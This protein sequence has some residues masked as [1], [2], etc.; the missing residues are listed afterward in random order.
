MN[1][2]FKLN[3]IARRAGHTTMIA[4]AVKDCRGVMICCDS[5]NASQVAK[6]F[7]IQTISLHN[8]ERLIGNKKPS[9]FDHKAVS[10][11][12]SH[13]E[14]EIETLTKRMLKAE[15][16]EA[17]AN[18]EIKN[19]VYNN[20]ILYEQLKR[21]SNYLCGYWKESFTKDDNGKG[22]EDTAIRLLE[23]SRKSDEIFEKVLKE[24]D[25][26]E[27]W[28]GDVDVNQN[29]YEDWNRTETIRELIKEAFIEI[30]ELKK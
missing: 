3:Y 12:A 9:V 30:K 6:E 25:D 24:L 28:D 20:G 26:D 10:N 16:G 29:Y 13:Y 7:G 1:D 5:R 4:K 14:S 23:L 27:N 19:L 22:P 17:K 21:L 8:I 15:Q 11:M 18:R 2:I